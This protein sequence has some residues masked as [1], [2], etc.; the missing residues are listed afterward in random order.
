M[1]QSACL[2]QSRL[3]T[4]LLSLI[5]RRWVGRQTQWWPD[6]KLFSLVGWGRRFFV[7]CLAHRRSAVGFLLLQCSSGVLRHPRDLQ[8]SVATLCF[9]RVLIYIYLWCICFPLWSI[10]ELENL[11][12]DRTTVWFEPWQKPRGRWGSH[13]SGLSPPP[14]QYF[15]TD[16]SKAVLLLWFLTVTCSCCPYLQFGSHIMLVTYC[17]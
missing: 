1:R 14:P 12:A 6:I 15:N 16:R 17:N 13:K 8:V 3:I 2:T 7:C 9:C 10:D 11:H 4:L 5:A